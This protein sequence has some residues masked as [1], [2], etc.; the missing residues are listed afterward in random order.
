MGKGRRL[1]SDI[2]YDNVLIQCHTTDG[3]NFK[4]VFFVIQGWF[5]IELT[6]QTIL[7]K[8]I[9]RTIKNHIPENIIY[10]DRIIPIC[11]LPANLQHNNNKTQYEYT[12]FLKKPNSMRP[13]D[14]EPYTKVIMD[15]VYGEHF[16]DKE[17]S[18]KTKR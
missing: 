5:D 18:T 14:L 11:E 1:N 2:E 13:S 17:F 15:E 7:H 12:M 10:K 4:S 16:K 8:N 3:V 9:I 6:Q